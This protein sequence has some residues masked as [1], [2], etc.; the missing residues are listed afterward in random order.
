MKFVLFQLICKKIQ[1]C[2]KIANY[3]RQV[4]SK[5]AFNFEVKCQDALFS[6]NSR[7]NV[8]QKISKVVFHKLKRRE[9]KMSR[10]N[11]RHK[12]I[13]YLPVFIDCTKTPTKV[14]KG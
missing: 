4:E 9:V 12:K 1:R 13:E 3:I 2:H 8:S 6:K 10:S 11:G 7:K 5:S 14:P